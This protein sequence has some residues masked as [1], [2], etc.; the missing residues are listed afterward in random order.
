MKVFARLVVSWPLSGE[1]DG[2]GKEGEQTRKSAW[3][4]RGGKLG[5]WGGEDDGGGKE[6]EQ[7]RKSAWGQ[8]DSKLVCWG[9][10]DD[11]EFEW[12]GERIEVFW[13]VGGVI[14][15]FL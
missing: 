9:G 12:W 2:G 6:G 13:L 1:E 11:G 15:L 3:G 4:Q 14:M 10:E 7:T 8:R 5:C